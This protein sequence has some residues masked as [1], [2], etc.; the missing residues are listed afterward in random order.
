VVSETFYRLLSENGHGVE[1]ILVVDRLPENSPERAFLVRYVIGEGGGGEAARPL[2]KDELTGYD[3][4]SKVTFPTQTVQLNA[5]H[6]TLEPMMY[7]SPYSELRNLFVENASTK[8]RKHVKV[9]VS[10]QLT[11]G[12][13]NLYQFAR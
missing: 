1:P 9:I 7:G 10:E 5:L 2:F 3:Y 8:D 4:G 13:V 12:L 6:V 11:A